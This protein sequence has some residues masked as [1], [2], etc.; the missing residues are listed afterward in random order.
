MSDIPNPPE[1]DAPYG[2]MLVELRGIRANMDTRFDAVTREQDHTREWLGRCSAAIERMSETLTR[3][4]SLETRLAVHEGVV[5]DVELDVA[6]LQTEIADLKQEGAKN[7]F[8]R[9]GLVSFVTAALTAALT[10][11]GV[12]VLGLQGGN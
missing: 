7:R 5:S 3:T 12:K 6:A 9:E 4:V 10:A 8:I 1:G 2:A 11:I